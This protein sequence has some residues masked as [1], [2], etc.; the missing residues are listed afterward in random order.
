MDFSIR[1]IPYLV[2]VSLCAYCSRGDHSNQPV[3]IIIPFLGLNISTSLVNHHFPHMKYG[4]LNALHLSIL[5]VARQKRR[6]CWLVNMWY[7]LLQQKVWPQ[8]PGRRRNRSPDCQRYWRCPAGWSDLSCTWTK[9]FWQ[10]TEG[11]ALPFPSR[12]CLGG[13]L[14]PV[15]RKI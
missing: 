7:P 8:P 9:N 6:F 5:H 1:D 12:A 11:R 10:A 13:G 4:R 3:K 15:E 2:M 14:R